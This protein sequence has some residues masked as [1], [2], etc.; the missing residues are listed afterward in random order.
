MRKHTQLTFAL[1]QG[2]S[3][4]ADGLPL[5]FLTFQPLESSPSSPTVSCPKKGAAPF[6]HL[7]F[8][9]FFCLSH[10][11]PLSQPSTPQL[12]FLG[13]QPNP[14][15][16]EWAS[17]LPK[18]IE[19]GSWDCQRNIYCRALQE[20]FAALVFWGV[21]ALLQQDL[22]TQGRDWKKMGVTEYLVSSYLLG[23]VLLERWARGIGR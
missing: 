21:F 14:L 23:K 12:L 16:F 22:L 1:K 8:L 15:G 18:H 9:L 10:V 5:W 11:W 6:A 19:L 17:S 13:P 4:Q 20:L 7:S 3:Q 2:E